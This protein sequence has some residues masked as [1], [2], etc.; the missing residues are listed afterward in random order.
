MPNVDL[1]RV[2]AVEP[3]EPVLKLGQVDNNAP[4]LSTPKSGPHRKLSYL[5]H[6]EPRPQKG[7]NG[8][9]SR[10]G[11]ARQRHG[12]DSGV[13][14]TLSLSRPNAHAQCSLAA[15]IGVKNVHS[16]ETLSDRT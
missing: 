12:R 7:R 14:D 11:R 2:H 6:R 8:R 3:G 10:A 15:A 1:V 4:A 13:T 5:H 16:V 9:L